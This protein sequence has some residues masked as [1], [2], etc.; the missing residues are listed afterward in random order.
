[1]LSILSDMVKRIMEVYMDDITIFG[2][3]FE[4]CL[5][6]LETILRKC[7]EINLVLNDSCHSRCT[8]INK[9]YILG[10]LLP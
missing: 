4:E 3:T 5:A 1:M 8:G 7:I 10:F 2:G 6:N 9:I